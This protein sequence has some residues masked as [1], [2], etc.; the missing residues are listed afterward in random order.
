MGDIHPSSK[1]SGE[2]EVRALMDAQA[3]GSGTEDTRFG[4]LLLDRFGA[5][6]SQSASF[7]G[8]HA[9]Y[10]LILEILRALLESEMESALLQFQRQ[11][12][13]RQEA[14]RQTAL[15]WGA[16]SL[17]AEL[18]LKLPPPDVQPLAVDMGGEYI[19]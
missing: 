9:P 14:N 13:S 1:R 7:H 12:L 5:Q 17:H 6:A 8:D 4:R 2:L 11:R 16:L 3:A 15:F 10:G 18:S 19:I